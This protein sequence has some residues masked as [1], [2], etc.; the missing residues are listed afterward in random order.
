MVVK[1]CPQ[2]SSWLLFAVY[3]STRIA[4]RRILWNNLLSI[5]ELNNLPWLLAGD[6]NFHTSRTFPYLIFKGHCLLI[7]RKTMILALL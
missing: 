2:N 1:V 6:L 3:A 5:S 7:I 4:K